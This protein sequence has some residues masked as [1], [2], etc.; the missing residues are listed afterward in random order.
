MT[1]TLV[2][3]TGL[4]SVFTSRT[5]RETLNNSVMKQHNSS[6]RSANG[7]YLSLIIAFF[8][9]LL[10][11]SKTKTTTTTTTTTTTEKASKKRYA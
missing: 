1:L 5:F 11:V 9:A 3:V 8:Q 4:K 10:G 7:T 2:L 6:Q